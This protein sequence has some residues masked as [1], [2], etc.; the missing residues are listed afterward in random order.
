MRILLISG[1][2]F[3]GSPLSSELSR[4]GHQLAI[5]H[6][7][8]DTS[9]SGSDTLRIHGD[10]NSLSDYVDQLRRF[11]PDL[12]IDMILSSGDQA[13]QLI[14]VARELGVRAGF[15]WTTKTNGWGFFTFGHHPL[16]YAKSAAEAPASECASCH[17]AYVA[18][19]DMTWVQ[20]YPLPL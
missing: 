8:A 5:F 14:K 16:P 12:I 2:G 11:S 3:I 13:R 15:F 19:T 1:N 9:S 7:H 17:Q 18:K 4:S 20:F 10:R 6:R